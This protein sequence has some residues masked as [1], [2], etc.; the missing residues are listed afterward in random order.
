MKFWKHLIKFRKSLLKSCEKFCEILEE[1]WWSFK[2]NLVKSKEQ[3]GEKL[4]E[5]LD[6]NLRTI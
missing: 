5:K 2:E 1:N 4:W 3:F 6:E